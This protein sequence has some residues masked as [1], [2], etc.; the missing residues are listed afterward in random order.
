MIRRPPR[1][2]LFPYTTLFRSAVVEELR[3]VD[4]DDLRGRSD[5][6][7]DFAGA[8]HGLGLDGDAVV[9]RDVVEPGVAGVEVGLEDLDLLAGDHGPTHPADQLLGLS[10]EH[11]PGDDLDPTRASCVE[12]TKAPVG[13]GRSPGEFPDAKLSVPPRLKL[14]RLPTEFLA[15]TSNLAS[16][17]GSGG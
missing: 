3:L 5:A 14:P 15:T 7:H 17:N 12:Q 9:R 11:D 10:R 16:G 4:G 13:S 1:S 2:T 8:V 6:L